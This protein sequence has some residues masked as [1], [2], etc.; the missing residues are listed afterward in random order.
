M[1]SVP[2]APPAPI[3]GPEKPSG[4]SGKGVLYGNSNYYPYCIAIRIKIMLK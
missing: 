3:R 1:D 4:F 2:F